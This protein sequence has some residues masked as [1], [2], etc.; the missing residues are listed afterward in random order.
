MF[1]QAVKL[2]LSQPDTKT[3]RY[4]FFLDEVRQGSFG[5]HL[6]RLAT[7]GRSKGA[8]MVV[9]VQDIE[10]L[11]DMMNQNRADEFLGVCSTQIFMQTNNP[12]TAQWASERMG[13][14]LLLIPEKSTSISKSTNTNAPSLGEE[15]F[16]TLVSKLLK[17]R[18]TPGSKDGR[19]RTR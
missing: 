4:T 12:A 13:K 16:D 7:V 2:V 10:G 6:A 17:A 1:G 11:R 8:G 15:E 3:K 5:S 19:K 18:S 14:Q 9:G